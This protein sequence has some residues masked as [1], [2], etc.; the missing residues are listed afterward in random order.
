MKQ[1]SKKAIITTEKSH[2]NKQG[3]LCYLLKQIDTVVSK[4]DEQ[5]KYYYTAFY[6]ADYEP[7]FDELGNETHKELKIIGQKDNPNEPE[8]FTYE[9]I[10][11]LFKAMVYPK[12]TQE[13]LKDNILVEVLSERFYLYYDETNNDNTYDI[14]PA[15]WVELTDDLLIKR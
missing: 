4:E 12:L 14:A 13:Q 2:T 1:I 10:K 11:Q 7:V 8:F 5:K 3:R 15:N 6:Y 9:Q